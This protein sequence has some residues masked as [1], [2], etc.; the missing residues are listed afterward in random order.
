[1]PAPFHLRSGSNPESTRFLGRCR[2]CSAT[3][4][5]PEVCFLYIVCPHLATNVS[6]GSWL[7]SNSVVGVKLSL[8][9][10]PGSLFSPQ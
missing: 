7:F 8:L 3:I 9:H 2:K 1:M 10:V 5:V 6:F 4:P